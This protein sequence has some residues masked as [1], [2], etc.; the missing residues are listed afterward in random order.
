MLSQESTPSAAVSF[1]DEMGQSMAFA[2]KKKQA[3]ADHATTGLITLPGGWGGGDGGA[4]QTG[5]RRTLSPRVMAMRPQTSAARMG[6]GGS[7][8]ARPFTSSHSARPFIL[9]DARVTTGRFGRAL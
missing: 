2:E 9:N 5:D 7:H 1:L 8:S 6:E 4:D 3:A